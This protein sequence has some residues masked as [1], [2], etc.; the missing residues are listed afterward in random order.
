[1]PV[2]LFILF[3]AI[4]SFASEVA[5]DSLVNSEIKPAE[6]VSKNIPLPRQT[7]YTGKGLSIGIAGGVYDPTEDCDCVGNWQGQ[8]EYFYTPSVSGGVDVRFLGGNLDSDVMIMYQRYRLNV[9]VHKV[10]EKLDMYLEP[11]LELENTSISE[12]R[13]QVRTHNSDLRQDGWVLSL[14]Q[15]TT[16]VDSI[17]ENCEKMFSLDGFSFGVGAGFGASLGEFLGVTGSVL[18]EYNFS[19][20]IQLTLTPGVALNLQRIWAW[21]AKNLR[22]TWVSLEIGTQRFFNRGVGEWASFVFLGIQIGV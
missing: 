20:A 4:F 10:F 6:Q 1:M 3:T 19:R 13:E 5:T 18:L 11:V 17:R 12:F 15:D 21:S 2:L 22:S 8:L 9:R 16:Q 14:P 7:A